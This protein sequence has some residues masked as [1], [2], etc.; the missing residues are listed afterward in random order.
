MNRHSEEATMNNKLAVTGIDVMGLGEVL[1]RSGF[2]SDTRD[3]AQAV[4]KVLAGQ[5]LGFVRSP[6]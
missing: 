1:A 6:L 5:E 3:A 2:F 4:V